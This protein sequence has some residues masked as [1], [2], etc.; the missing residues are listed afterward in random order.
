MKVGEVWAID[1][2]YEDDP[3]QSKV[4]PCII[5]DIND[6]ECTLEV[7]TIKVTTHDSRDDYD[8]PIFKWKE[9][10]LPE[11]SFARVSKTNIFRQ[12]DFLKK[13]GE[14]HV[15]DFK[16]IVSKFIEYTQTSD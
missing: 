12:N 9:A 4:R 3:T 13:Y 10:N 8:V 5:L 15:V 14:L 7:L 11:P 6:D 1:F 2:P 16:N